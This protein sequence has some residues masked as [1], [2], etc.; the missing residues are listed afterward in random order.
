MYGGLFGDLPAAKN[1]SKED[2][3]VATAGDRSAAA[4]APKPLDDSNE[5]ISKDSKEPPKS[6]LSVVK[7]IGAAG[8]SIAFVPTAALNRRRN[9]K[10]SAPAAPSST[11][12]VQPPQRQE[13]PLSSQT[14]VST[15][16]LATGWSVHVDETKP[17]ADQAGNASSADTIPASVG[18]HEVKHTDERLDLQKQISEDPYDPMIPNDLLQYWENKALAVERERLERET[19]DTLEQQQH[20]R[21]QLEREREELQ[22]SGN[23]DRLVEH[24][25]KRSMGRG[26]GL[27]NLPAWL[28][29]KQ[30]KEREVGNDGG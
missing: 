18:A 15:S 10:R 11:S 7:N 17:N 25:T 9:N 8:T 28:V 4:T 1:A 5:I 22:K 30:R 13:Q 16:L 23:V 6:E 14:E 27:S 2:D 24:H 26:R 3:A 21:Q 12:F 20:L 19:R 29:E